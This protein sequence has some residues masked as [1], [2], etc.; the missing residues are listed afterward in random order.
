MNVTLPN[1]QVITGVPEG[2]SKADIQQKAISSGLA[3]ESDFPANVAPAG[4]TPRNIGFTPTVTPE[5]KGFMQGL[6]DFVAGGAEGERN[7]FAAP[8]LNEMSWRAAKSGLGGLLTGDPAEIQQIIASNYPD[9]E[10]GDIGGQMAVRFP[11]GD[12]LLQPEGID[13]LDI[14]RFGTDVAAFTPAGKIVGAGVKQ[15]AKGTAVAGLTQTGLQG[16][17]AAVG[18]EF[19]P[20]DVALEVATQGALQVAAPVV[21]AGIGKVRETTAP[22]IAKILGKFKS[23]DSAAPYEDVAKALTKE[24]NIMPEIMA[25]PEVLKAANDL[26]INVNPSVYSTS[27]I[28]REMENGIKAI[29]GSKLSA[30]EKETVRALGQKADDLLLEWTGT[31]DKSAISADFSERML[32]T[33][34]SMEDEA[35]VIYNQLDEVIPKSLKI[36]PTSTKG[37]ID[38]Y[39]TDLGGID[40]LD[41]Q[42][43]RIYAQITQEVGPTYALLDKLRRDIGSGLKGQGPFKD[44]SQNEMKRL[45]GTLTDDTLKAAELFG[46]VDE[47]VAV[48]GLV[49]SR[50]A[51]EKSLQ[52]AL[53]KDLSKSLMA[54]LSAGVKG[55]QLGKDAK[56]N[57]IMASIPED[58]RQQVAI[59]ALNDIF[60]GGATK[61]KQFSLGGFVGS[62]ESLMRNPRAAQKLFD[63]IP[64]EV[65]NRVDSIYK[66]SKG[67]MDANVKDLNNPSGTARAV[68]GAMDAPNG[69]INK[70]FKVGG[71]MSAGAAATAPFD[72]GVTGAGFGL[73]NAL[74][75]AKTKATQAAEDLITNPAFQDSMQKFIDGDNVAANGVLN[76]LK[77][78]K[79]WIANQPP[80]VKRAIARQGLIQYLISEGEQ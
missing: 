45:Y 57:K 1:G 29:P 34:K 52:G 73:M 17:E 70:L 47:A 43:K 11:S 69:I 46:L 35:A 7:V 53:G 66:V 27:D 78:T 31:T 41:P 38:E 10:F 76:R 74:R 18:G 55:L 50:K 20:E 64:A 63:H 77:S 67:L 24:Q 42:M 9:A 3:T 65:K 32:A 62:Y 28:Y 26:G 80:E 40:N 54:E 12:Y 36:D 79:D 60:A 61:A 6:K 2:T 30:N 23:G 8:E 44:G 19:D 39:I 13:P 16:V 33:V 71:Q 56:F 15:L 58:E 14:A 49:K 75:G 72:A 59:S 51:L 22:I 68:I 48:K 21:K 5:K 25:D 4:D 37:V